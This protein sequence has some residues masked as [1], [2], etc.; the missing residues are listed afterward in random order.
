[1]AAKGNTAEGIIDLK[2][3]GEEFGKN[4]KDIRSNI[5]QMYKEVQLLEAGS[6]EW[7]AKMEEI[8]KAEAVLNRVKDKA[9]ELKNQY[10]ETAKSATEGNKEML[11]I[12]PLGGILGEVNQGWNAMQGFVQGNITRFGVLRGAIAATGIGALLL[13]FVGLFQYLTKTDEGAKKLEGAMNGLR[14]GFNLIMKPVQDLGKYLVWAFE[15]PKKAMADL[16]DFLVN[17][18]INRFKAFGVILEGIVEMDFKKIGDG[19]VQLAS[20]VEHASDKMSDLWQGAQKLADELGKAFDQGAALADLM[21]TI[22]ERESNLLVTNAKAEEQIG[23]LLLQAKD[24]TKTESERLAL[25]DRA[26]NLE[27]KRL[28][29]SIQLSQLK[30]NAAKMEYDQAAKTENQSDEQYRKLKEAEAELINLRAS[31]LELQE[32]ITNRRNALLDSEEATRKAA[33][34]LEA[35]QRED[36]AKKELDVARRYSDLVVANIAD[37]SERK[38][39]QIELAYQRSLQDAQLNGTLTTELELQLRI[40]R[41]TAITALEKSIEDRRREEIIRKQDIQAEEQRAAVDA[42]ILSEEVKEQKVYEINRLSLQ[43]RLILLRDQYGAQSNE[44]RK[45]QNEILKLDTEHYRKR[46]ELAT[47]SE[48]VKVALA[49]A[50]L[51]ASAQTFRGFQDLLSADEEARRKNAT[52][53]KVFKMAELITSGIVEVGNIWKH[54]ADLG[55]VAGPIFA[56]IQTGLA[57]ART[58]FGVGR[59]ATTLFRKGAMFSPLGGHAN[60]GQSHED[61]GIHLVDG[62][63]GSHYG[64]MERGEFIMILSRQAYA[65]NRSTADALLNSSLY[66]NGAPIMRSGGMFADGALL[67]IPKNPADVG[68]A[69]G[70]SN[71]LLSQLIMIMSRVE[72]NTATFPTLIKAV[73]EYEQV[74]EQMQEASGIEDK[75]NA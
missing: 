70:Y 30:L 9:S 8:G 5:N 19:T 22:D 3:N 12:T 32:K 27:V 64:E 74:I 61:G 26:N 25:L 21:D 47:R 60:F 73:V 51:E 56:A 36:L 72:H 29:E 31:S 41:D 57:G 23:R 39:A 71:E 38:R 14:L 68:S 10:K 62:K 35:K 50:G 45:A 55:P 6:A 49:K 1:M 28:Q 59:I 18:L 11:A 48:N 40:Q 43:N 24:R 33:A 16:G 2:L 13:L 17:N 44:V 67:N 65:N 58:T 46:T 37:E 20:G 54:A 34:D 7:I 69:A 66:N 53:I 75:A 4:L 42:L 15:N 63:D 52:A